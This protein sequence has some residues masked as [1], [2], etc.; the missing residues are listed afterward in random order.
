MATRRR[1]MLWALALAHAWQAEGERDATVCS[2]GAEHSAAGVVARPVPK[3]PVRFP[4][5]LLDDRPADIMFSGY[6]NVTQEDFLFYW[7]I[8]AKSDAPA[9]APVILWSNGGPG[10]TSMEGAVTEI[11]PLLLKGVKT[12]HSTWCSPEGRMY[13]LASVGRRRLSSNP[14]AWN[15]RAHVLLVDQPRYVGYSTGAGPFVLSSKDAAKDI[16]QFLRG[17]RRLFPE[18]AASRFVLASESYGGHFIPAFAEA[19]FNFNDRTPAETIQIAGMVFSSTCIDKHQ[20]GLESFTRFAKK[21]KLLPSHANPSSMSAARYQVWSHINYLPNTY[22]YRLASAGPCCGCMG[23]NYSDFDR[24]FTHLAVRKALNVCG[25]AGAD[26]FAGC[27]AGC[28]VFPG[29]FDAYDDADN[30]QTM[31]KVLEMKIPILM[32]YGMKDATC[33]YVGG[34]SIASSL[35]WAGAEQWANAPLQPFYLG[36]EVAGK[37]Q[38][39]GGLTWMQITEAGHMVP[40]DQPR[41][42]L[43]GI[44][45]LLDEV[46][47]AS[48]F[49]EDFRL[50]PVM[51]LGR[52]YQ[53][54]SSTLVVLLLLTVLISFSVVRYLSSSRIDHQPLYNSEASCDA[55]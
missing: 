5:E 44:N 3:A 33:N 45:R 26:S 51:G 34:Y 23:Y 16:V 19:I 12:G 24:W 54:S 22:D 42:I 14:F 13:A 40:A 20:Q 39:G 7:F 32:A 36:H 27:G 43:L 28:I 53:T 8:Q 11:G 31:S 47:V 18:L 9:D 41:A 46:S 10:C 6:V 17:W 25:D 29:E 50:G 37:E 15:Q 1:A 38:S 52:T 30:V 48:G 21:E 55:K 4:K 49:Q 2:A 35:R